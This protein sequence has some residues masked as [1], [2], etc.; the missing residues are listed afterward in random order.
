MI[1]QIAPS[2]RL[3][4]A[5]RRRNI[6]FAAPV[7]AGENLVFADNLAL[8]PFVKLKAPDLPGRMGA[9]SYSRST[10]HP[11][12]SIGRYCSISADV[13]FTIE[14]HPTGR[15]T[16]A[17][18]F[19]APNGPGPEF[20]RQNG[21]TLPAHRRPPVADT[22]IGHDVWIGHGARIRSGVTIG[23]GAVIGTGAVV[24]KDVPPYA[25]VGGVPARVIRYRFDETTIERLRAL[26]WW[27]FAPDVL[28][29]SDSTDPQVFLAEIER[30]VAGGAREMRPVRFTAADFLAIIADLPAGGSAAGDAD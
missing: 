11:S 30:V 28:Q 4:V 1:H 22:R 20:A 26:A 7:L 27:R 5:L 21:V 9:F 18:L 14:D 3:F 23:D 2:G 10:L 25:I 13:A 12:V 6:L 24:V 17:S 8:E 29:V 19:Y 16:N 15:F